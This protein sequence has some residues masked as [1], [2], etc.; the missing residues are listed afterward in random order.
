MRTTEVIVLRDE[1]SRASVVALAVREDWARTGQ[2]DRGHLV[3]ASEQWAPR[4]DVTVTWVENHTADVR[5]LRVVG[6]ETS[7]TEVVATLRAA[8]PHDTRAALLDAARVR[9]GPAGLIRVAGKLAECRPPQCDAEQLTVL[10]RLLSHEE[11]AVRRAAIRTAYR[12]P[13]PQLL[14]LVQTRLATES[15][16]Q[17][18][19]EHLLEFL[20]VTTDTA[21][22]THM[23]AP[24]ESTGK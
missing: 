12:Y 24:S 1:V 22:T 11:T 5:L 3:M 23:Q 18:Q 2:T 16:L 21:D 13:W 8:L 9:S 7:V 19:L 10:G 14:E 17:A 6:S 15:R 4:S 20:R